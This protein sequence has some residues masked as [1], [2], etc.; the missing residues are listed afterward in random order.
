VRDLTGRSVYFCAADAFTGRKAKISLRQSQRGRFAVHDHR[1]AD[2]EYD[3]RKFIHLIQEIYVASSLNISTFRLSVRGFDLDADHPWRGSLPFEN[4]PWILHQHNLDLR[5]GNS[6][7]LQGRDHVVV[8]VQVMP[9]RQH[10]GEL[11]FR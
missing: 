10:G 8:N 2:Y 7:V 3:I 9:S 1:D 11:P 6:L 4:P 5:V